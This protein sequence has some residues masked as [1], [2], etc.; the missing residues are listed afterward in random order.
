MNFDALSRPAITPSE[1]GLTHGLESLQSREV[2]LRNLSTEKR[3]EEL[4][5]ATQ[6]FEG[7]FIS[8]LLKVMRSTVEET[9]EEASNLGKQTYMEMFDQ[10]I[11]LQ[12][13]RSHSLGIG[14]MLYRQLSE[15][16]KD[17]PTGQRPQAINST[18][19]PLPRKDQ[20]TSVPPWEIRRS[21]STLQTP[22]E[23]ETPF[24]NS[25]HDPMDLSLPVQGRWASSFGMRSDPY[26][27]DPRFHRG[28]DIAASTGSPIR[29]A[30]AGTVLYSGSMKGYGN[31]VII[32]HE[33]GFRTLYA[34]AASNLVTAGQVVKS[35]EVIGI[36]GSTGRSTGPHLHFELQRE[37]E[38]V[39]PR[40][41]L[42]TALSR[43]E[44]QPI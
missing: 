20:E 37:G 41:H 23:P 14:E 43:Q 35:L 13:A 25:I 40:E 32:E 29:A 31:T 26:T 8:Y 3:A 33:G 38:S 17:S 2:Q 5:K 1:A 44:N 36:V 18:G 24:D 15:N 6:E 42:M 27:H 22:A 21:E 34:H 19:T 12:I 30:Q 28:V 11:G 39:D 4:K 7:I 9:D 10:E 16:S